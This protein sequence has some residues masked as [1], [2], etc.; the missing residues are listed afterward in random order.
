[1]FQKKPTK[2]QYARPVR[3][4]NNFIQFSMQ[5]ITAIRTN[6][7]QM[8][9]EIGV[10]KACNIHRKT[11]VLE[12]LFSKVLEGYKFIKKRLQHRCFPVNIANFLRAP[13][14]AVSVLEIHREFDYKNREIDEI[15]IC[16]II[17]CASITYFFVFF[18]FNFAEVIKKCH[19]NYF[20]N[21]DDCRTIHL[22]L[23]KKIVTRFDKK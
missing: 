19:T 4:L 10:L 21:Y 15:Y 22:F 13:P 3:F 14:V 17:L 23:I 5:Y 2:V 11:P 6:R 1:M 8:F 18:A 7:S 16:N 9:F 12:S 20:E